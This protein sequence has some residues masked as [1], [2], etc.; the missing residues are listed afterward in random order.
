[1]THL[2]TKD[3]VETAPTHAEGISMVLFLCSIK[4][5]HRQSALGLSRHLV[6]AGIFIQFHQIF[7]EC[8]YVSGAGV[9]RVRRPGV[10]KWIP[11]FGVVTQLS[12]SVDKVGG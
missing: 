3:I 9:I 8:Y 1:M 2:L 5:V 11:E 12:C 6:S 4:R 10:T 7:T